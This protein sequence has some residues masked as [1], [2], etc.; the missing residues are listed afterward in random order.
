MNRSYLSIIIVWLMTGNA[1]RSLPALLTPPSGTSEIASRVLVLL[2]AVTGVVAVLSIW[3]RRTFA[4]QITLFWG[5]LVITDV[6]A[7]DTAAG[8]FRSGLAIRLMVT[9]LL[10]LVVG[11]A[12]YR[13]QTVSPAHE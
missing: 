10:A 5:A 9:C 4:R 3:K 8:F 11:V 6:V 12:V 7:Q 2:I 13:V 1:L